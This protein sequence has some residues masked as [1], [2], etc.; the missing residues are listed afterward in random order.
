[1]FKKITLS[2]LSAFILFI[3]WPPITQFTFLIFIAFV[4]LFILETYLKK[5]DISFKE[6]SLYIYFAF[7]LFNICTTF[8][9]KNAHFG[10][11][12]FAILCNS[13]FMA[14]VFCFY[15][16]TKQILRWKYSFCI[17]P[18]FWI[19]F[20][21]LHLNWDLSWPW[22][23]IGNVFASKTGWVQWYS[24][25]G[26]LGGTLWVF[27]LNFLFFQ[28]Y[29]ACD[30]KQKL[31]Y[32]SMAFFSLIIPV[33]CSMFIY[34]KVI[35]LTPKDS[36]NVLVVQP[37]MNPYTE[38]FSIPQKVQTDLLFNLIYPSVD[39]KL[40]F[41]ILPETFLISSVWHHRIQDNL[42]V[43]RFNILIK[44]FPNLS[45]VVG[46][47][48]FQLSEK[49]PRSKPLPS[50]PDQWYKAYNS[51][52]HLNRA[53]IDIYNKSKLVP[54]AEQMPFQNL[55]HPLLGDR[56]LQIGSSTAVGNFAIQDTVS[57][58]S[59]LSGHKVAPII[60]YESIYGD[61]VRKFIK[62][63]ADMIFIITNDGWWKKT[64]GYQQHS[65]YA[66]LRAIETRRYIARSANTGISSIINHV[67]KIEENIFWDKKG[68]IKYAMPLYSKITFYVRHGDVIGRLCSFFSVFI[69]LYSFVFNKLK[70]KTK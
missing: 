40:D 65:M 3:S 18:V 26:V 66:T 45:I 69:L 44:K 42:D 14:S 31:Q 5:N 58:F 55:L 67:G 37:N 1:M 53:G 35:N 70:I 59:A 48:T 57:L 32:V 15:V 61:Y 63:G 16:K 6:Y 23:T 38:K 50:Q 43:D 24:W 39:E 21:Y 25:T 36:V 56:I 22:L 68:V 7:F 17:L 10:G 20:E 2:L 8:W 29:Q 51:A 46:A 28:L 33:I 9:V 13:F 34:N 12:V 60:C 41:L 54:G 30:K 4:P 52:L 49:G 19:G 62:K 47:V 64:S 27:V 11:A